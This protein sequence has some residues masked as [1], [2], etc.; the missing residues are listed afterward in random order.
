MLGV[1]PA[2][3]W[4]GRKEPGIA[5]IH[6]SVY[7]VSGTM[8]R[9]WFRFLP[10][11][12]NASDAWPRGSTDLAVRPDHRRPGALQTRVP[13][14]RVRSGRDVVSRCAPGCSAGGDGIRGR[15]RD[16]TTE[17]RRRNG[18]C[19]TWPSAPADRIDCS[20]IS[21]EYS[22]TTPSHHWCKPRSRTL[23]SRPF[24]HSTT[25]MD[26]RGERSCTSCSSVAA[27]HRSSFRQSV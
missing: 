22:M 23:S 20:P 12:W 4:N 11:P 7:C 14:R 16:S 5:S 17:S 13:L 24:I 19:A 3:S 15:A 1:V 8:R 27:P 25:G 2:R 6:S 26:E 9:A 18:A 10:C 21:A